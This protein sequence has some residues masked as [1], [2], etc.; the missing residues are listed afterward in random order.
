MKKTVTLVLSAIVILFVT[1]SYKVRN[2]TGIAGKT[3]SPGES[4]C[5]ECHSG[6]SSASTGVTLSASPEFT[7]DQYVAGTTYT[8]SV[9]I[10]ATG[11]SRFGFGC[12]IL[13]SLSANAGTMQAITGT[14]VKLLNAGLRR[15]AT[16]STPKSGTDAATFK[17]RWIAPTID[18]AT[19]YVC[20]NAVNFNGNTGGDLPIPHSFVLTRMPEPVD[21]SSTD[22]NTT[23]IRELQIGN[24]RLHI[25]PNPASMLT[26]VT[27]EIKDQTSVS[28]ELLDI[29]GKLV[30]TLSNEKQAAGG[31]SIFVS[32]QG[33][34]PGVYFIRLNGDNRKI[35]QKLI[36]VL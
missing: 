34:S 18:T 15:N 21:T 3:G 1:S 26:T 31:H 9:T 7:L 20:G 14:G 2:S 35:S 25:Y 10:G 13:D 30:R 6:G 28:L 12:E 22:T 29:S 27:Y 32:L 4:T 17:F 33:V 23:F 16:H 5:S 19:F 36:T 11:F 8:V 24:A